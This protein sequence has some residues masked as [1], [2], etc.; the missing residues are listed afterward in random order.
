MNHIIT[1]ETR[2]AE[3]IPDMCVVRTALCL[4]FQIRGNDESGNGPMNKPIKKKIHLQEKTLSDTK[5]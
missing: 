2:L 5:S 1:R 4:I 3:W